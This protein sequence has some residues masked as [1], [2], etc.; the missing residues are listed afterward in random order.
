M[1]E[2]KRPQSHLDA[3]EY[4]SEIAAH[5]KG[6]GLSRRDILKKVGLAGA[7][8][9]PLAGALSAVGSTANPFEVGSAMAGTRKRG[10]GK[11]TMFASN[12]GLVPTWYAQGM[13]YQQYYCGLLGIDYTYADGELDPVKQRA[14]VENAAAKKWDIVHIDAVAQGTVTAPLKKMIAGG[15]LVFQGPGEAGKPG[16]DY[17]YTGWVHQSSFQMGFL[18]ASELFKKVGGKGTVI[19]TQG[20]AAAAPAQER[21]QGFQAALK[22]FPGMK[23]LTTDFG[24][25]DPAKVQ[26][27][28]ETYVNRYPKIDVGYFHNDDMA[29]AGYQVLKTRGRPAKPVL[30]GGAAMPEA[31]KA[32]QDGR[33]VATIRHSSA[34]VHSYPVLIG[35]AMKMGA[36]G[37]PPK[38]IFI[39]GPLVTKDNAASIIYLQQDKLALI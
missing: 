12:C 22:A 23:L 6:S 20:P 28:W 16:E 4:G 26:K 7:L 9:V 36:V 33:F 3:E 30:G 14:K 10:A 34:R 17:G 19:Q 2:E 32:V 27:Q 24:D 35:Y 15:A 37:K 21:N 39:D 18:V 13:K 8:A 5:Y 31:I 38:E 25:W 1:S 29:L 11:L